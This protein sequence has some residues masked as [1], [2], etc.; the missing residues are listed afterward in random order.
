MFLSI[1][2]RPIL[3]CVIRDLLSINFHRF[4]LPS[5]LII[6]F[7]KKRIFSFFVTAIVRSA[8]RLDYDE[9]AAELNCN[10]RTEA[11]RPLKTKSKSA[12]YP[13]ARVLKN[14]LSNKYIQVVELR[15]YRCW[16]LDAVVESTIFRGYF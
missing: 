3:Q 9:N 14:A 13:K 15:V 7:F 2:F 8:F 11:V 5:D 4:S 10:C 1:K 16:R 12:Q 6:V